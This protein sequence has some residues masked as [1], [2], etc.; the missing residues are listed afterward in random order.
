MNSRWGSF[1]A[2]L[3]KPEPWPGSRRLLCLDGLTRDEN[4]RRRTDEGRFA[5]NCHVRLQLSALGRQ[6][7]I[8]EDVMFKLRRIVL[9][10]VGVA[11]LSTRA[12][13]QGSPENVMVIQ[14]SGIR[15]QA[16][17]GYPPG[18]ERAVLEGHTDST[19]PITY[20]VRL[21]NG[22]RFQPHTHDWTE[23]VTVLEGVWKLGVGNT[24]DAKRMR[25]LSAGSFIILPGGV[26]HF[27]LA[28]GNTILQ[29]HGMGPV[30]LHFV[31]TDTTA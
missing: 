12:L 19:G 24:F 1:L 13:A 22:F 16:V 7:T 10:A 17:P 29:V 15:W 27:V 20:R 23:H 26:P 18:Y 30:G 4:K 3:P 11:L 8:S 28:E 21:P 9:G 2:N 25:H 31:K 14:P 5:R 6:Q